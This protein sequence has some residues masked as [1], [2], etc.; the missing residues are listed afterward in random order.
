MQKHEQEKLLAGWLEG[1]LTDT[2]QEQFEALCAENVDFA[3]RVAAARH[4]TE[5][6]TLTGENMNVPEWNRDSTFTAPEKQ[7][8]W[9]WQGLPA[10]SV[11]MSLV[12]LVMVVSGFQVQISEGGVTIGFSQPAHKE[13]EVAAIV[14]EKLQKYQQLNELMFSKYADAMAAQQRESSAQLTQYLLASGRQERREDFA[15]FVKFINQQR[16]DDQRFM[17]RQL[18]HLKQEINAMENSYSADLPVTE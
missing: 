13:N 15:E 16:D 6:A 4:L 7:R 11:A 5:L 17:A 2:E 10:M 8:W 14:D 1:T 18:N 3:E 12:A 9:Q